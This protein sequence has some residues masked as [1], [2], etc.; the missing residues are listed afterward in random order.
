MADARGKTLEGANNELRKI[1][2]DNGI[3][4]PK[5]LSA[6]A[7][8]AA[9]RREAFANMHGAPAERM[10]DAAV[11]NSDSARIALRVAALQ[12]KGIEI[13]VDEAVIADIFDHCDADGDGAIDYEEFVDV[14]SSRATHAL[15]SNRQRH[16]HDAPPPTPVCT[17]ASCRPEREEGFTRASF[18]GN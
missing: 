12:D 4:V 17:G 16:T 18:P 8:N 11:A 15:S 7:L 14:R 2:E 3:A 5:H 1:M 10:L 9:G 13:P 6:A